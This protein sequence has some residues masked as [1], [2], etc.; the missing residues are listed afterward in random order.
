MAFRIYPNIKENMSYVNMDDTY[1]EKNG[2][3]NTNI[4]PGAAAAV[5]MS[6][7]KYGNS[8]NNYLRLATLK[9]VNMELFFQKFKENQS[10]INIDYTNGM[11]AGAPVGTFMYRESPAMNFVNQVNQEN[12][13]NPYGGVYSI[14]KK[15]RNNGRE[16]VSMNAGAGA[17]TKKSNLLPVMRFTNLFNQ[18]NYDNS[19]CNSTDSQSEEESHQT[20][21]DLSL[22]LHIIAPRFASII[23]RSDSVSTSTYTNNSDHTNYRE[24]K[25][26]ND[27]NHSD[28]RGVKHRYQKQID[29][30]TYLKRQK[31]INSVYEK[32]TQFCIERNIIADKDEHIS[33]DLLRIYVTSAYAINNIYNIL[34]QMSNA[35]KISKVQTRV[36]MKS[37]TQKK[38]FILFM[39]FADNNEIPKV[40]EIINKHC[41]AVKN[42]LD[43]TK[44]FTFMCEDE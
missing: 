13:Y 26:R 3:K 14:P 17:P 4:Y 24:V 23:A 2:R 7:T 39:K 12:Y 42:T 21:I 35:V 28:Y 19:Y 22:P 30:N 6:Q 37:K 38:G 44:D 5:R 9:K 18:E 41:E 8:Y 16:D 33:G 20:V 15:E 43:Q 40:K 32:V 1:Y 34:N 31:L 27:S 29:N 36:S 25:H 11:C 10:R